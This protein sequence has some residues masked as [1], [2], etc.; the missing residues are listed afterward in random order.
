MDTFLGALLKLI[1]NVIMVGSA[2]V[3]LFVIVI[4]L[5][6][7]ERHN[8]L[9]LN[10]LVFFIMVGLPYLF[11]HGL[12][13]IGK[14]LQENK[15]VGVVWEPVENAPSSAMANS[16]TPTAFEPPRFRQRR[17][18]REV[19]VDVEPEQAT[20]SPPATPEVTAAPRRSVDNKPD[21]TSMGVDTFIDPD[22][23]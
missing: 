2:I 4:M 6:P 20:A 17:P 19:D 11:G 15:P 1:G 16:I 10:I 7:L 21:P 14:R 23:R 9:G 13:S 22:K 12:H 5:N 8:S 3:G 18:A